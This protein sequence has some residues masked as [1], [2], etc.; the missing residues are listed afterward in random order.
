MVSWHLGTCR[1]TVRSGQ[2]RHLSAR[3]V[4]RQINHPKGASRRIQ[5][6][7]ERPKANQQH[8]LQVGCRQDSQPHQSG[9]RQR[10]PSHISS[11]AP[12]HSR[13]HRAI[14]WLNQ[15]ASVHRSH[16][17][18]GIPKPQSTINNSTGC[19]KLCSN[20]MDCPLVL[21]SI[22]VY[23]R[24]SSSNHDQ[25]R[26]RCR[27]P[28]RN[29][30]LRNINN[31]PKHNRSQLPKVMPT[32]THSNHSVFNSPSR[33]VSLRST[34]NRPRS[35]GWP[36]LRGNCVNLLGHPKQ[37]QEPRHLG[38]LQRRLQGKLLGKH[39]VLQDMRAQVSLYQGRLSPSSHH[40]S[41][42]Y[43]HSSLGSKMGSREKVCSS[44][45]RNPHCTDPCNSSPYLSRPGSRQAL[46]SLSKLGHHH[47][48]YH[49]Q[50]RRL[51]RAH[52]GHLKQTLSLAHK[53]LA[54]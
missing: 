27:T 40:L 30:I 38:R 24:A 5:T 43:L 10:L 9:I 41:R 31:A 49:Q 17:L 26:P 42:I 23:L 21:S 6:R 52:C 8:R 33:L 2:I 35:N 15:M 1:Q 29:N 18:P 16:S 51:L 11:R 22:L 45:Q 44:S 4:Q 54:R 20:S 7:I 13:Q 14:P 50:P 47:S 36:S 3:G 53:A 12:R 28:N 34:H 25:G 48:R 32:R 46:N 19:P 39:P 37:R